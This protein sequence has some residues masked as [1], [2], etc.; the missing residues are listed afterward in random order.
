MYQLKA[1]HNFPDSSLSSEVDI[2]S[3]SRLSQQ[4]SNQ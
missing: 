3:S 2:R 1:L 4:I